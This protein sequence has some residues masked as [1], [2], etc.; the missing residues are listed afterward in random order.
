[1]TYALKYVSI[2][3][4]LSVDYAGAPAALA[5]LYTAAYIRKGDFRGML[6]KMKEVL[7]YNMFRAGADQ[8][9]FQ[10]NIEALTLCDDK[11]LVEEGINYPFGRMAILCPVYVII[12]PIKTSMNWSTVITVT[13]F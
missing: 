12:F 6:D 4:L 5:Q 7:S 2:G 8:H 3:Y 1:M 11:A 13:W 10:N 9:Y